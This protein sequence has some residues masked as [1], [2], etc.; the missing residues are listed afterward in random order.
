MS[1]TRRLKNVVI[2]FQTILSFVL[3]RIILLSFPCNYDN[4]TLKLHRGKRCYPDEGWLFLL[5]DSKF[6]VYQE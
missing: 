6:E 1:E 3:S 5:A 2:L 4:L